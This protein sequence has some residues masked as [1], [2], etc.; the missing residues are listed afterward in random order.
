MAGQHD[1]GSVGIALR[2]RLPDHLREFEAI[3]NRHRPVGDDDVRDV[4][5]VHF[6]RSRAVFGF[7]DL[8]G[9]ERMQQRPQNAAHM[10]I[11][12]A[13]KESQLVEIDAKHGPALRGRTG[14]TVYRH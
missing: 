13:H 1:D 12:V 10:R 8:A 3:E 5:A 2:F 7:I 11:V 4:V 6:E 9:A 14:E